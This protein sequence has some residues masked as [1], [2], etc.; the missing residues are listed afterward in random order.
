M[1]YCV[2]FQN[3]LKELRF[4]GCH[5][6]TLDTLEGLDS[7]EFLHIR[8]VT[9]G[10]APFRGLTR[11]HHLTI[12]DSEFKNA[13]ADLFECLSNLRVLKNHSPKNASHVI[14]SNLPAVKCLVLNSPK[15]IS[16]LKDKCMQPSLLYFSTHGP[17]P[18]LDS[19]RKTHTFFSQVNNSTLEALQLSGCRLC[20]FDGEWMSGFAN[21]KHLVLAGN[22]IASVKLEYEFLGRLESLD[23]DS[24]R[25]H[26]LEF[27]FSHFSNLKHLD[28][29][30]NQGL[31]VNEEVFVGLEKLE[32]LY[33]SNS[34]SRNKLN[35]NVFRHLKNL[36]TLDISGNY[37][38]KLNPEVFI[39]TP[40]LT[41]LNI[42]DNQLMTF[43]RAS[44]GPIA[45]NLN[46]LNLS[47]NELER[48]DDGAFVGFESLE[49]LN[50]SQN[51]ITHVNERTFEGLDALENLNLQDNKFDNRASIHAQAFTH[52]KN[53]VRVH[54]NIRNYRE[55]SC[56][57]M[58]NIYGQNVT[59]VF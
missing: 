12:W 25:I 41:C 42:S 44:L 19:Q 10:A 48:I 38:G 24:N 32:Q 35:S 9:L 45:R 1:D 33:L 47:R 29:G 28:L 11:L 59:L 40:H 17:F 2:I 57:E 4:I 31:N 39:H 53:T 22:Q 3:F 36:R 16:Y 30:Y 15:M 5:M 8:S 20:R 34:V 6:Q 49:T 52:M 13:R 55:L 54:L 43:N 51:R 46:Y 21:L 7:L 58:E 56:D 18:D 26:S 23:L 37:L 14:Y 27:A 50:L